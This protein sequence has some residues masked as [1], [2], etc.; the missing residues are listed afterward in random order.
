MYPPPPTGDP[1]LEAF[2]EAARVY[3]SEGSSVTAA[4]FDPSEELLWVGHASGRLC[5]YLQ[6][7]MAKHTAR[8]VVAGKEALPP[9][10]DVQ[11]TAICQLEV[12]DQG[13]VAV[14]PFGAQL[15]SR[16]CLKRAQFSGEVKVPKVRGA[17]GGMK[18]VEVLTSSA[19]S[20]PVGL[21]YGSGAIDATH[22]VLG[23]F[24]SPDNSPRLYSL[25]LY[26]GLALTTVVNLPDEAGCTSLAAGALLAA[27]GSD[28]K[29]RLLD[30]HLRSPSIQGSCVAHSGSVLAVA[31][32]LDGLYLASAGQALSSLNPY[33]K[34]APQ[35]VRPDSSIAIYDVRMMRKGTP[36]QLGSMLAPV[37]LAF[38][39]AGGADQG[40]Q[41]LALASAGGQLTVSHD[42]FGL[43]GGIGTGAVDVYQLC[44]E[45]GAPEPLS[46]ISASST[47]GVIALGSN[48]SA[49]L[50]VVRADGAAP[51]VNEASRDTITP[52]FPAAPAPVYVHPQ[53]P[54]P[55]ACHYLARQSIKQYYQSGPL[56]SSFAHAPWVHT[57][58]ML[59][60]PARSISSELLNGASKLGFLGVVPNPGY[61]PNSLL[62]GAG[63]AA[64]DIC[65]PRL[66]REGN[67]GM[68]ERDLLLEQLEEM[69]LEDLPERYRYTEVRLGKR[70]Y[71]DFDFGEYN[72]TAFAGLENH[73]PNAY[74]NALLQLLYLVPEVRCI[75]LA[76]Q[77]NRLN[78]STHT[79]LTCELGFL[80]QMLDMAKTLPSKN[81]ACHS[82]NFL[83]SFRLVPE[84]LALGVLGDQQ[85]GVPLARRAEVFHRFMLSQIHKDVC[86]AGSSTTNS[87]LDA[88]YGYDI[89]TTNV[90]V[91]SGATGD[92]KEARAY[93]TDMIAV[94]E[95]TSN[96]GKK[97]SSEGLNY[98]ADIL[99]Q[100]L[101]RS[102]KTRA[103]SKDEGTYM[104]ITQTRVPV[105]LP[106]VLPIHCAS[107][108][109]SAATLA[110]F[111]GTNKA[112]GAW[113][114]QVVEVVLREGCVLE[115]GEQVGTGK[116][117]EDW[118]WALVGEG[119]GEG[120]EGSKGEVIQRVRY[121]L[122]AAVSQVVHEQGGKP[123]KDSDAPS[124]Q[125]HLV[126]HV[127]P[128]AEYLERAQK[129][130][131]GSLDLTHAGKKEGT[132]EQEDASWLLFNDFRV[133]ETSAADA[134][135]Y[136]HSWKEPCILVYRQQQPAPEPPELPDLSA[137]H[138]SP[139]V[140]NVPS[141]SKV[142]SRAL[143][144]SSLPGAG[145]V[146]AIDAEFVALE[147]EEA[148]LRTDGSRV[149][150]KQ[151]RQ[152]LA[153]VSVVARGQAAQLLVLLDD[154]VVQTEPVVDYLTRFS[155]V[156]R[157]DLDPA[158]SKHNVTHLSTLYLKLRYLLDMGCRF[159]G[160]GLSK[161]FRVINL[162]VPPSQVID[163]LQ[164]WSVPGRRKISLRFLAHHLLGMS[165]QGETH[166]S[167]EDSRIALCL[168]E[169]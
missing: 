115:V 162:A 12:F 103:W 123:S 21:P 167:I 137:L 81:R 148:R 166:D 35:T 71:H 163:T 127:K 105:S 89:R 87:A 135:D 143:D 138:I 75:A 169:K 149:V 73:I 78:V 106:A 42:P 144:V 160:H 1:H 156:S 153:R 100:S 111:R 16:G 10:Q 94:E 93:V 77:F 85:E 107:A 98:F 20:S 46:C 22:V 112:G 63:K 17:G 56:A 164:L 9:S 109:E 83:S 13:V 168:Y 69:M 33:D 134:R 117:E 44:N 47:G 122:A 3:D 57:R 145:D 8:K 147:L 27:G 61:P 142:S 5:S 4:S 70:G 48:S 125:L 49:C 14:S 7:S 118:Y 121:G 11:G 114:P 165:I 80:F 133:Q 64:Y 34:N 161:D 136:S 40:L 52:P 28:G 26:S 76:E 95:S 130:R 124:K 116:G 67:G 50:Q 128:P 32:S 152:G 108:I 59:R 86:R 39:P 29:L 90:F 54:S 68:E 151:G 101:R 119:K 79:S 36:L 155:G 82:S 6:P 65:D 30:P 140:F 113:V 38:M 25:D 45:H 74:T 150:V 129:D 51:S 88:V 120:E 15:V 18:V 139:D 141:L 24:G 96:R 55:A 43:V 104:P 132:A 131:R 158:V 84:A 37:D 91:Q 19:L 31:A 92:V 110:R 146:L 66:K 60:P 97:S 159:L 41:S 126:L 154:Y 23:S 72:K 53:D 102:S 62:F 157:A 2:C 99:A 58:V